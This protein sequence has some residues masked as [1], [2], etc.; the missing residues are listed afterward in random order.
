MSSSRAARIALALLGLACLISLTFACARATASQASAPLAPPPTG[1]VYTTDP[2]LAGDTRFASYDVML[3][4]GAFPLA[5]WQVEIVDASG[6]AKVVAVEGGQHLAFAEP[7]HYDPRALM[8]GRIV[9]AA[10]TTGETLPEGSF[11]VARVHFAIEGAQEP[12]LTLRVMAAAG[13]DGSTISVRS[14]LVRS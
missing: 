14:A 5:A 4:S 10:F 3:D 9:L 11:R 7:P 1:S 6:R 2:K 12:T 13:S 8:H